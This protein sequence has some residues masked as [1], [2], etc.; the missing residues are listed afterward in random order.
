MKKIIALILMSLGF[1]LPAFAQINHT[2]ILVDNGGIPVANPFPK[3]SPWGFNNDWLSVNSPEDLTTPKPERW[4]TYGTEVYKKAK[5]AGMLFQRFWVANGMIQTEGEEPIWNAA[6]AVLREADLNGIS[7]YMGISSAPRWMTGGQEWFETYACYFWDWNALIRQEMA[8]KNL[9]FAQMAAKYDTGDWPWRFV[10]D[11][12]PCSTA[13]NYPI[14][15]KKF[16]SFIGKLIN[17][18]PQVQ[19]WGF[20][21]EMRQ[22]IGWPPSWGLST[23]AS[24]KTAIDMLLKPA[25]EAVKSANRHLRVVGPEGDDSYEYLESILRQ[26]DEFIRSGGHPFFDVI[27]FHL[28][29]KRDPLPVDKQ[30]PDHPEDAMIWPSD[31]WYIFQHNFVPVLDKY[32]RGRPIWLTEFGAWTLAYPDDQARSELLQADL[33]EA[34]LKLVWVEM[35]VKHAT[36]RLEKAF[37]YRLADGRSWWSPDTDNPGCGILHSDYPGYTPREAY[38]RFK[39][40]CPSR[41]VLPQLLP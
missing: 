17:R 13:R 12:P 36:W 14:D 35:G 23:D 20:G 9:T 5:D 27:S 2:P 22:A 11:L 40:F 41:Q 1:V 6:D 7:T 25:Y 10:Y 16:G 34:M 24:A 18:Y 15:H 29:G 32:G 31:A 3:G 26:E 37:V 33:L 39:D 38:W 21:N 8:D 30:R 4:S 28:Y 19:Y